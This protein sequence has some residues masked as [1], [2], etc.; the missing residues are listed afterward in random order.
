MQAL[1]S[2]QE[3]LYPVILSALDKLEEPLGGLVARAHFL[4]ERTY[5]KFMWADWPEHLS[6]SLTEKVEVFLSQHSVLQRLDQ[7]CEEWGVVFGG[8]TDS[9]AAAEIGKRLLMHFPEPE[10]K[11]WVVAQRDGRGKVLAWSFTEGIGEI[12]WRV[13]WRHV[14]AEPATTARPA[15]G[16]LSG[17]DMT[18]LNATILDVHRWA[19]RRIQPILDEL[20]NKLSSAYGDRFRGLYVF[21]SY[22]RPDAGIKL[23]EDSDLDVALLLSDMSNAYDEMKR[24]GSVTSDLS[25]KYGLVVSVTPIREDDYSRDRTNFIRV[26]KEDAIA[27]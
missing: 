18:S 3:Q 10:R 4:N 21:G 13:S 6:A 11:H 8:E 5:A 16:R 17:D 2:Y 26:I 7:H 9:E 27:V 12:L 20:H 19:Q 25:A 22:A 14:G 23:P 1:A 15:I 24:F